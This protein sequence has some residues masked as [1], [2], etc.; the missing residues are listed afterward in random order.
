MNGT[1]TGSASPPGRCLVC[2]ASRDLSVEIFFDRLLIF[3]HLYVS[4]SLFFFKV[5]VEVR[6]CLASAYL[7]TSR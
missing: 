4:F 3:L 1:R 6:S 2:L 5:E 7:V